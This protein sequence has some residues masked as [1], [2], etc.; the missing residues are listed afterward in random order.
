MVFLF[1]GAV[2]VVVLPLALLVFGT[3]YADGLIAVIPS[4]PLKANELV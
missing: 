4:K 1:G 2:S 3:R